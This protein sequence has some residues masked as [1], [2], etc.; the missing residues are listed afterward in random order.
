MMLILILLT[1]L[2]VH[3][4]TKSEV[5]EAR[6]SIR[7]LISPLLPGP[8]KAASKLMKDFRVDKCQTEKINWTDVLLMRST[9]TLV[10][11][12]KEGCD[13]EGSVVPKI[14]SPFPADIKLRNL[15]LYDRVES[16]NKVNATIDSKPIM[17]IELRDGALHAQ[18][19]KV[20]FEADYKV[21]LDPMNKKK[22][23]DKNYG[24]ELRINE[25]YGEKVSIKEKIY[26]E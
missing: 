15:K 2:T 22:P 25:I 10:F 24:G 16:M 11:K 4:S 12:F 1:H 20:K 7:S 23:V 21:R 3:A 6:A 19:G 17:T 26:V 9:V 18:K 14:F 5:E 8:K 13:V